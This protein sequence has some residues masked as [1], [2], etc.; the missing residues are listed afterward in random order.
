MFP[1]KSLL[2]TSYVVTAA[3]LL[4]RFNVVSPFVHTL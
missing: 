1:I 2:V 4:D 3:V